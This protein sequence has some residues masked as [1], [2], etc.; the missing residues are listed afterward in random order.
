M[1]SHGLLRAI[2]DDAGLES[3]A[4]MLPGSVAKAVERFEAGGRRLKGRFRGFEAT[5]IVEM[6]FTTGH[7]KSSLYGRMVHDLAADQLARVRNPLHVRRLTEA[8]SV[9]AVAM[10]CEADRMAIEAG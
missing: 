10:A 8:D 6:S 4:R 9:A 1:L 7:D 3:L 5:Q 2:V